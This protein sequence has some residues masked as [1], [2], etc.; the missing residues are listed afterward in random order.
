MKQILGLDLGNASIGWAHVQ[1]AENDQEKSSIVDCGVR[2]VPLTAD[3]KNNFIG[4]K[5]ITTNADRTLKR[6]MRRNNQRYKLRRD[7]LIRL[8]REGGLITKT[9]KLCED[10]KGTTHETLRL[11]AKAAREKVTTEELARVLLTINKKRGYK[12]N[13]K[14]D[15]KDEGAIIDGISVA[16]ELQKRGITPGAYAY[17]LLKPNEGKRTKIP[18][19][20]RSDLEVEYGKVWEKQSSYYP[21][22]L[23]DDL[24]NKVYGKRANATYAILSPVF[25]V[26][27]KKPSLSREEKKRRPYYLRDKAL[28]EKLELGELIEA[29]QSINSDLNNTSSYLGLIS[30]RSKELYFE[31]L[32]VG[33]YLY[34]IIKADHH[35]PLTNLVFFR[36]DYLNEFNRIWQTQKA[37]YPKLLTDSLM[38]EIRDYVIFYQRKLRSQKNLVAFCELIRTQVGDRVVGPRVAPKS[39]PLFQMT[40]IRQNLNDLT[41]RLDQPG[42]KPGEIDPETKEMLFE[43]LDMRGDLSDKEVLE[44]IFEDK[45]EADRYKLNFKKIQGNRTNRDLYNAYLRILD[46]E[47]Y[48]IGTIIDGKPLRDDKYDIKDAKL[49]AREVKANIRAIFR[50]LGIE[51]RILDFDP[52]LDKKAYSTQPAYTLWHLLY[53]YVSDDSVSGNETLYKALKRNYGFSQRQSE[54]LSRVTLSDDYGN[55]STAALKKIYPHLAQGYGYSEACEK[56]GFRHSATS[57]TK[58]ENDT[59]PLKDKLEI[60]PKNSLRQPVVEKILN[61]MVHVVNT[62]MERNAEEGKPFHFDEIHIELAR[63]LKQSAAERE[64]AK[65]EID[66]ATKINEE[67]RKELMEKYKIPRPTRNDIIRLKLW[68]ELAPIGH[69]DPYS[70]IEIPQEEI[71]SKDV[72]VDHIIPQSVVFDDSFSNKVLTYKDFNIRKGNMTAYDYLD[73]L[74]RNELA[75]FLERVELLRKDASFS[76]SK[77]KKL[78]RKKSEVGD[79]FIERDL[80]A[81]Q[82][83]SHYAMGLLREVTRDVLPTS[84]QITAK[85]REDF[86]LM[87]VL[88]ELELPKYRALGLTEKHV[89]ESG[90]IIEDI[91]DWTKCN[92]NRHHAMDAITIAFTKRSH[93][94]YLNHLNARTEEE[95]RWHPVVIGVRNKSMTRDQENGGKWRFRKPYEDI[96]SDAKRH[97]SSILVSYKSGNKVVT[98]H[99]NKTKG[100]P[101]HT[102]ITLTPRGALHEET[103]YGVRLLSSLEAR[104]INPN[105]SYEVILSIPDKGIRT[106]LLRRLEQYGGDH[107]KAFG[108]PALRKN[109]ILYNGEELKEVEIRTEETRYSIRKKVSDIKAKDLPTIP[110]KRVREVLQ[111][112]LDLFG[113][114]EDKAFANSDEEPILLDEAHRIPLKKVTITRALSNVVP[115]HVA[116]DHL[117]HI[118]EEEGAPKPKDF[119][120]L[121]GNHHVVLFLDGNGQIQ[122]TIVSFFEAV[123]RATAHETIIRKVHPGWTFLL[124]MKRNDYFVFKNEKTGF[125]PKAIDLTDPKNRALISPNLYRVQKMSTNYYVF[126]HHLESTLDREIKDVTFKRIHG[127]KSPLLDAVK[128]RLNHLGEVVEVV[129]E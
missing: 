55:L 112:R 16:E 38:K 8:M 28:G 80:C 1:L 119:V 24:R 117:G 116:K 74:G 4:G 89:L 100:N 62:L 48:D 50:D 104:K 115:L 54:I 7:N 18:P 70:G 27:A 106:L 42:A 78:L 96:R 33:E 43:E 120:D 95:S 51:T 103:V 37:Y 122:E 11:R 56:A 72:D 61:Q 79:G 39:S 32:T 124:S 91:K 99:L 46:D 94:Q 21:D 90:K 19:F 111:R 34:R 113:G 40:K 10:G 97:I 68:K 77:A 41:C 73:S 17:E 6:S 20:Y 93:I 60:L 63:E 110:D 102:Q 66:N 52:Y 65:K 75:G 35:R 49:P 44:L 109:P 22:L 108:T 121:G 14:M 101:G 88:K 98:P 58:E 59:R 29:L 53:S 47:G 2:V 123:R 125:D 128:V 3:E 118:I 85:L 30:D 57:I 127:N 92:D 81:S 69:K 23:T 12:S 76:K 26:D 71:F 86:G 84:G 31:G 129:E 45:K 25:G 126:R 5:A 67:I 64:S 114:K 13:R 36:Q 87:E 82:Y 105:L 9:S 83:I 15:S 107:K